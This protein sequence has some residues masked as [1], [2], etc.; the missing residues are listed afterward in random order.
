M[1]RAQ[2]RGYAALAITDEC[3]LAGVVRAH[4]EAKRL[5]FALII[6]AEMRL[7]AVPAPPLLDG[8]AVAAG[9]DPHDPV[10]SLSPH[11]ALPQGDALRLVVL[12]TSRRGYGLLSR[13]ITVCRRR[14]PKGQYLALASDLEGAIPHEPALAGLSDCLALLVPQPWQTPESLCAQALWLRHWLGD[15]AY[16]AIELQ[17]RPHDAH[18]LAIVEQVAAITGM[19]VVAAGDVLMHARSRKPLLDVVTAT[20]LKRPIADCGFEL[21][22]NAEA[23]LRSRQR[24]AALYRPQWLAESVEIA[25]RCRFSLDEL[26][27]EYPREI[28]PE[29]HTPAS[30]L[31]ELTER[32]A[33]KRYA[34]LALGV[35]QKVRDLI[36]HELALIG[37]LRYEP[38]FLTVADVVQWARAKGILCQG[39]G[40]AANSAVCYTCRSPR[41][42][43]IR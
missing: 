7:Q 12:A 41:S 42:T 24:L 18:A 1:A 20:R 2:A 43:R 8:D 11:I 5:S 29:G 37:Q 22:G 27:Y 30:W 35:P 13:W 21:A 9:L 17:H 16:L 25:A 34:H 33:H 32:G 28:V 39:R 31:R 19:A 15:R 38:Y 26:Q 6:G 40:S 14:A 36:E 4:D 3:S 10:G 23:H